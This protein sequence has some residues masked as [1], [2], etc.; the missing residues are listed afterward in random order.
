MQCCELCNAADRLKSEG[1]APRG[2]ALAVT[3]AVVQQEFVRHMQQCHLLRA[4]LH[5]GGALC[6]VLRAVAR[7]S[8]ARPH[9]AVSH[10][11]RVIAP[12]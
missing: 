4:K 5:D 11:A 2:S 6:Q 7:H 10:S 1:P 3:T 8:I 12:E 9:V